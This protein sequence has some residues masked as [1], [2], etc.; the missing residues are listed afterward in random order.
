MQCCIGYRLEKPI[1]KTTLQTTNEIFIKKNYYSLLTKL[2]LSFI[3]CPISSTAIFYDHGLR[4][5]GT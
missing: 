5:H 2:R 3:S 4:V 1:Y